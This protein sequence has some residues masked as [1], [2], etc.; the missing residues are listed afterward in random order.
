MAKLPYTGIVEFSSNLDALDNKY[1]LFLD[2]DQHQFELTTFKNKSRWIKY[3]GYFIVDYDAR[4]F[5][6]QFQ[7][8]IH[9]YDDNSEL[10]K[11]IEKQIT[12]HYKYVKQIVFHSRCPVSS[13]YTTN[14]LYFDKDIE[15]FL[16][17]VQNDNYTE[18]FNKLYKISNI[19]D[20]D[21]DIEKENEMYVKP[22]S[23]KILWKCLS[24]RK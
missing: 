24:N 6:L 1:D 2:F 16:N 4:T 18:Y 22:Y 19:N 17:S 5:H 12:L 3:E 8:E 23:T 14:I 9:A 11:G 7:H 20:F 21:Q 13:Y 10:I 15:C